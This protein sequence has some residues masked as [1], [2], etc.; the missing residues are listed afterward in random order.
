MTWSIIGQDAGL[1]DV[2]IHYEFEEADGATAANTGTD[3]SV[4]AATLTGTTGRTD[5]GVFG[6]GVDLP[7]GAN[8]NAVDLPDNLLQGAADF[9]TSFWVRPDAKANWI[10][11][12]HIGDGLGDAGSFFQIQ[13]QTQASGN[14]GLAATFKAKGNILQERVYANPVKDVVANQWN[15]VAFTRQGETGTLYLNGVP[16]A[17]R[18]NLT[19]DMTDIGPTSNNWLG[20]N[21][22][23][24]PRAQ[25]ADRRRPA[26]PVDARRR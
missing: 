15:H 9:S 4:G 20:R 10:G 25:R 19:I 24:G 16:I 8:T 22:Y 2:P 13:M 1:N 7:G 18:N 6:K 17:S 3:G 23:P 26:L 5:A 14:T 12:F 21:G 11:M